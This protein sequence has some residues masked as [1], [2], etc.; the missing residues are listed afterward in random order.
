MDTTWTGRLV[1]SFCGYA[2]G[3]VYTLDDG[4]KWQQDD[5]TD[6]PACREDPTA[7]LLFRPDTGELFL[8]VEGTSSRVRITR[9]GSRPTPRAGAV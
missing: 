5:R 6:E 1:G 2:Y 7:R 8:D 4:S 9:C 3:R